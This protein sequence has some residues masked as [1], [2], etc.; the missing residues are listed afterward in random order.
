M[1]SIYRDFFLSY[2]KLLRSTA[3]HMQLPTE[4]INIHLRLKMNLRVALST[5]LKIIDRAPIK[6]KKLKIFLSS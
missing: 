4:A 6:L 1:L 3:L 2:L 5:R